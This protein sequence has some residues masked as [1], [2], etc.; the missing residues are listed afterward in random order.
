VRD[1]DAKEGSECWM[2]GA[3]AVETE[4]EFIQVGLD[5]LANALIGREDIYVCTTVLLES[6]W[7]PRSG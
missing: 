6:E 1:D 7:V 3:P 4:F 5:S 2:P